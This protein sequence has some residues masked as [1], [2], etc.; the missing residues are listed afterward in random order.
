MGEP[1]VRDPA[2]LVERVRRQMASHGDFAHLEMKVTGPHLV[3]T[4]A[5]EAVARLTALGHDAFGLAFHDT[6]AGWQPMLCIDTLDDIVAGMT[7]ALD[8]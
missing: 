7:A 1:S 8:S 3:I 5:R 4:H 6:Q 2:D